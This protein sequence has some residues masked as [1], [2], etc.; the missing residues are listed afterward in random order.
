MSNGNYVDLVNPVRFAGLPWNLIFGSS[1]GQLYK[2]HPGGY[3]KSVVTLGVQPEAG[4]M[5]AAHQAE[6][7]Y[8][9]GHG[10]Q[11]TFVMWPDEF[12]GAVKPKNSKP[13]VSYF[14]GAE[15]DPE[16]D[17]TCITDSVIDLPEQI[18]LT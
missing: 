1:V 7:T 18:Q 11:A 10:M 9:A 5:V 13:G 12:G 3:L 2:L 8:V 6:L 14:N 16:G 17:W 15:I 4:R